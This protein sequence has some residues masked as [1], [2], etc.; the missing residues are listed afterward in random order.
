MH[1]LLTRMNKFLAVAIILATS[2]VA[3]PA[4]AG[5]GPQ[6]P[7]EAR[8]SGPEIVKQGDIVEY[9]IMIKNPHAGGQWN[10][11]GVVHTPAG[12]TFVSE[13]SAVCTG[14]AAA[15]RCHWN[16][17]QDWFTHIFRIRYRVTGACG[18]QTVVQLDLSSKMNATIWAKVTVSIACDAPTPTPTAVATATNTPPPVVVNTATPTPTATATGTPN[19]SV[20]VTKTGP[21]VIYRGGIFGYTVTVTNTGTSVVAPVSLIDTIPA[22]LTLFSAPYLGDLATQGCV[23]YPGSPSIIVCGPTSLQPGQTITY[24]FYFRVKSSVACSST[25]VNHVDVSSGNAAGA[26]SSASSTVACY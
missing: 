26:W 11:D 17:V 4:I 21:A 14:N 3:A 12:F 24:Y 19:N 13:D 25:I 9:T 8:V 6:G 20:V 23:F 5:G 1:T 22:G 16:D 15:V 7:M 2:F 10:V 18:Q